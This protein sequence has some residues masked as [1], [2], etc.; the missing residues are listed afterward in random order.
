MPYNFVADS[1][2]T[3][4]LCSRLSSSEVWFYA[5]PKT[6]VSRVWASVARWKNLRLHTLPISA[7]GLHLDDNDIL[8]VVGL[9]LGCAKLQTGKAAR[10]WTYKLLITSPKYKLTVRRTCK[11]VVVLPVAA[12]RWPFWD[13][14]TE[15]WCSILS[16][17]QDESLC[18]YLHRPRCIV[19][20][21]SI[22]V[23]TEPIRDRTRSAWC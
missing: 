2:H 15:C 12:D 5:T 7:C 20:Y 6:A 11:L 4:N 16:Y 22:P 18:S 1:F 9:R 21:F 10:K 3:K 17:I 13:T 23:H 19:S 8:V 14:E